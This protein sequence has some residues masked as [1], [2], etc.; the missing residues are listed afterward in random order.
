MM[1]V[2]RLNAFSVQV[3]SAYCISV[4][5]ANAW[6]EVRSFQTTVRTII[7]A[8]SSYRSFSTKLTKTDRAAVHGII[9]Y[10]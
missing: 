7:N 3:H 5:T 2:L 4:Y 10:N 8:K 6:K 9:I 1:T